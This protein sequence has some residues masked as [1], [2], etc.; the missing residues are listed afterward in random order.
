MRVTFFICAAFLGAIVVFTA[1]FLIYF[2]HNPDSAAKAALDSAPAP[3]SSYSV[4]AFG[5]LYTL[6]IIFAVLML[7]IF[8]IAKS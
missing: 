3:T 5:D 8:F 6:F 4:L 7:F 2:Q 1:A